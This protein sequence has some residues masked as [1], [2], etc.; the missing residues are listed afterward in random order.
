[1]FSMDGTLNLRR[2]IAVLLAGTLIASFPFLFFCNLA[3]L[4][5]LTKAF[6]IICLLDFIRRTTWRRP[7][8]TILA[9]FFLAEITAGLIL[10]LVHNFS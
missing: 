9:L 4:A 5:I 3:V 8:G 2:A 10:L 6:L 1:M 7:A